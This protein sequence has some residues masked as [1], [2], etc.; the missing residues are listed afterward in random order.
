MN[1]RYPDT[2][3]V[4]VDIP[5]L[6]GKSIS[7]TIMVKVP[8][9]IET[10]SGEVI[11]G[12]EAL[13][14]MDRAKARYMGLLLPDE[15][16]ALR[17]RLGMTQRELCELLQIGAKSY[18]RWETG[19]E[20]PS[21]LVNILLRGL[22]DG[23]LTVPYLRALGERKSDWWTVAYNWPRKPSQRKP[24]TLNISGHATAEPVSH[25]DGCYETKQPAA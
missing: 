7:E 15:I 11:L 20:R 8:C 9:R 16:A 25:E 12:G 23:R 2:T 4:P 6:D 24:Y 18:S 10:K 13:R 1:T 14:M 17:E 3:E 5:T 19:R 21:R 22:N